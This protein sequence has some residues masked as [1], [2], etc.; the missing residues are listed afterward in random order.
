MLRVGNMVSVKKKQ[1]VLFGWSHSISKV[2][3]LF[4]FLSGSFL[5]FFWIDIFVVH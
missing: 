1:F 2:T 3:F 5:L 4:F